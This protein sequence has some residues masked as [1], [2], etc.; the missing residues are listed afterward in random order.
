MRLSLLSLLIIMMHQTMHAQEW[1][2]ASSGEVIHHQYFSLS[3]MEAHEQ[4]EWVAYELTA[5]KAQGPNKRINDYREDP[6]IPTGSALLSDYK[7]SGFDRGH[8]MPAADAKF[9]PLAMSES[10]YLSNMSPQRNSFNGG[11]WNVLENRVRKWA[12]AKQH[13]YIVTG[14]VLS[15]FEGKIGQ[16]GVSIPAYFYKALLQIHEG[17]TS[18]IAFVLPNQQS[19]QPLSTF[20]VSVDSVEKLTGIDMYPFLPDEAEDRLEASTSTNG[21]FAT[22]KKKAK[23]NEVVR[24]TAE[25]A[26]AYIDDKV[27]VCGKI[28][29]TKYLPKSSKQITYLNFSEPYPLTPFTVV[30]YGEDRSNFKE[31][32]KVYYQDKEVCIQGRVTSYRGRPQMR[33]HHPVQEKKE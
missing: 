9:D 15:S 11:I 25:E 18:I 10:F 1:L 17:D 24:I 2:P 16:S 19:S 7:G 31:E 32:P 26:E 21:W 20:V 14:P 13:L 12:G 33:M 29:A 6:T 3:Y 22:A 30:I 8:L 27:I 28:V 23:N 5:A 4:A